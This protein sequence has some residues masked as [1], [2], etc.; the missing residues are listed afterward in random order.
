[1]NKKILLFICLLLIPVFAYTV[2]AG[3]P[4]CGL[5][6]CSPI[7]ITTAVPTTQLISFNVSTI[8]TTTVNFSVICGNSTNITCFNSSSTNITVCNAT[9]SVVC[10]IATTEYLN[11]RFNATNVTNITSVSISTGSPALGIIIASY[12]SMTALL[13]FAIRAQ[14]E[15]GIGAYRQKAT[16]AA[17]AG[18][19]IGLASYIA[20]NQ[21]D[22]PEYYGFT[23]KT[24]GNTAGVCIGRLDP[25]GV[26]T[27]AIEC[28]NTGLTVSKSAEIQIAEDRYHEYLSWVVTI[29]KDLDLASSKCVFGATDLAGPSGFLEN[30]LTG[31]MPDLGPNDRCKVGDIAPTNHPPT[32][33]GGN[34]FGTVLSA[35]TIS[36]PVLGVVTFFMLLYGDGVLKVPPTLASAPPGQNELSFLASLRSLP[37]QIIAPAT[38]EEYLGAI[39]R[40]NSPT[41]AAILKADVGFNSG[42]TFTEYKKITS[43]NLAASA[44]PA[45]TCIPGKQCYLGYET[46]QPGKSVVHIVD[47]QGNPTK[48]F[49]ATGTSST[50]VLPVLVSENPTVYGTKI[51]NGSRFMVLEGSSV[52]S[53]FEVGN[54]SVT[55]AAIIRANSSGGHAGDFMEWV[56]AGPSIDNHSVFLDFFNTSLTLFAVNPN[57]TT[58]FTT[59]KQVVI[60]TY[61]PDVNILNFQLD[62]QSFNGT[63]DSTNGT[64]VGC[65]FDGAN[66]PAAVGNGWCQAE[67]EKIWGMFQNYNLTISLV[68]DRAINLSS[69]HLVCRSFYDTW[70]INGNCTRLSNWTDSN[71]NCF[72]AN[73][74]VGYGAYAQ[75]IG[76]AVWINLTALAA[77]GY[78]LTNMPF[79]S[80]T[81]DATCEQIACEVIG[82]WVSGNT[83]EFTVNKTI[84]VTAI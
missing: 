2:F 4:A 69:L 53:A 78:N 16:E 50:G 56:A 59:D 48:S 33:E 64:C 52:V 5:T 43:D 26:D 82:T 62:F 22:H 17:E 8:N 57:G 79:G 13:L 58:R 54:F 20:K 80:I 38:N 83:Q 63:F 1:M 81:P 41:A 46:D 31:I 10:D 49:Y 39:K 21:E 44:E 25:L 3:D 30:R 51:I 55:D 70:Q 77:P 73:V 84:T 45:I 12:A 18:I 34:T 9:N 14:V 23:T 24:P 66:D 47:S 19:G 76:N 60:A 42:I 68:A 28:I 11:K 72:T 71:G 32:T 37:I 35:G 15:S 67:V 7:P 27:V 29:D 75:V 61:N 36:G 65:S 40:T 6:G 74:P